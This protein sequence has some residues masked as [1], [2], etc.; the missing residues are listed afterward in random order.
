M[1]F[2]VHYP[3]SLRWMNW[4]QWMDNKCFDASKHDNVHAKKRK[5]KGVF[6]WLIYLTIWTGAEI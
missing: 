2:S 3:M 4:R 6:S 5:I 1:M